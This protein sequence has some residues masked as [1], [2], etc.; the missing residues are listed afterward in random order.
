VKK[1]YIMALDVKNDEVIWAQKYRPKKVSD[2]IL[3]E[4]TKLMF[5]KFVSDKSV[6][7]LLLSG[8]P[9]TGKTTVAKAVLEELECDYI[10]INGSL[11][12]GIDT[13]RYE[14]SNFA[15]SVSFTGGRKY[16]I[17][18]EADY[19]TPNAQASFRNFIEEFSN[20]CGFIFTCNFKNRIIEPLW[21]R[22]TNIDFTIEKSEKPKLAAQFFKRVLAV[23]ENEKVEYEAKVVAKVI[24]QYFPNF[25]RVLNELQGYSA[26]GKIDEGIFK[27]L[28]GE[29]IDKV[30]DLMKEKNFTEIRKWCADNSDQDMTTLYRA[31]YDRA[32]EKVA[33]RSMPGFIVTLH[34]YLYKSAFVADHEVNLTAFLVEVM[35]E[36]NFN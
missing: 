23:L 24:E 28:K 25:R 34:E 6:P 5:Q 29:N 9:G 35:M 4:K 18:D 14:I 2:T 3:P 32:T 36:C 12:G 16:V 33:L 22:F 31:L 19:L 10:V 21:G 11:N 7:N 13:L 1:D 15:S 27:A 26:S 30:F 17:I 20:N 8:G